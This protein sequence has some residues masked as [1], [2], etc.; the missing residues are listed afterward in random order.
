MSVRLEI[1]F[2]DFL[3]W[4]CPACGEPRAQRWCDCRD[5]DCCPDCGCTGSMIVSTF[6][7]GINS[8]VLRCYRCG[9]DRSL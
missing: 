1:V 2:D 7:L 8:S 3:L 4:H 6:G 5:P 9:K